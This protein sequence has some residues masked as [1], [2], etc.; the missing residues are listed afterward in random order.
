M[1]FKLIDLEMFFYVCEI[2]FME[3]KNLGCCLFIVMGVFVIVLL[4]EM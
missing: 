1:Y 3:V 2:F 4:L